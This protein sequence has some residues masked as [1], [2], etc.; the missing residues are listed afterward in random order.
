MVPA[1]MEIVAVR[2]LIALLAI[3]L[4]VN[5]GVTVSLLKNKTN[6]PL[7]TAMGF[8]AIWMF[9]LLGAAVVG[10]VGESRRA[11]ARTGSATKSKSDGTWRAVAK[12]RSVKVSRPVDAKPLCCPEAAGA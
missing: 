10:L 9:P 2:L 4:F 11:A 1:L 5:L 12:A 8:C 7:E 3:A 6:R